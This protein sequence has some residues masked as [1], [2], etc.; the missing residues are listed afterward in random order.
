MNTYHFKVGNFECITISDGTYTYTPPI[1][2]LPPAFLFTNAPEEQLEYLLRKNNINPEQWKEWVSPYTCLLINTAEQKVLV[3]TGADGLGPNTGRLLQNL[4]TEGIEP[5]DIG[6]VILT[7][8]HPDHIGGNVNAQGKLTFPNAYYAMYKDEWDFWTSGEA[9][10]TLDEHSKEVLLGFARKYLP[11][12]KGRLK[13][14]ENGME[15]V[16]GIRAVGAPGHT[17]G[18]MAVLVSSGSEELLC[19]GDAVLHPIQ[20]ER[21]EWYAVVDLIPVQVTTSRRRLLSMAA[22]ENVVVLAFHFPFP[23]LGHVLKKDD[24]WQWSPIG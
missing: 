23:G 19:I 6:T 15:I 1:F 16:A 22:T 2:P 10:M 11:P 12:I 8:G 13:L 18:H 17:P 9:E 14:V 3:D 5:E 21:P 20:I 4:K 7:H 24:A